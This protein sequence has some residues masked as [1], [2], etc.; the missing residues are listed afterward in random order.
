[1]QFRV[2]LYNVYTFHGRP[3]VFSGRL[4]CYLGGNNYNSCAHNC[5][6]YEIKVALISREVPLV[7]RQPIVFA[8]KVPFS[9][10]YRAI[11]QLLK[12]R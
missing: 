4:N 1:M 5:N 8:R 10:N 2:Y 7:S 12:K 9:E 11:C 6:S 3:D